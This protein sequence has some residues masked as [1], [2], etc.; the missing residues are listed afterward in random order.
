MKGYTTKRVASKYRYC[1]SDGVTNGP[2]GN[3]LLAAETWLL[4]LY[5]LVLYRAAPICLL[6]TSHHRSRSPSLSPTPPSSGTDGA[7][8]G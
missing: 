2:D 3:L 6:I 7:D 8:R 1:E 5:W 4:R